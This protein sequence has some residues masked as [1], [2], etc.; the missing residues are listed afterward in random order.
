D[1]FLNLAMVRDTALQARVPFLNI[2][3][4]CTWTPSMRVPKSEEMRYLVYT[5]LAYGAQGISY[6]VYSCSGHT[7]MVA[8][9]DGSPTALYGALKSLNRE[10]AAIARQLAPHPPVAVYHSGMIPPGAQPLPGEAVFR[11]EPPVA[12]LSYK[13]PE[14]VRGFLIGLFGPEPE[15]ID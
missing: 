9:L 4:A 15:R 2:V 13:A 12:S 1:Y 7:G 11:F 3:Q 14:P 6:Y 5:T 10:F 8:N